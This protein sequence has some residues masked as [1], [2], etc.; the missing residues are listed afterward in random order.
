MAPQ[1]SVIMSAYNSS[2]TIERAIA[3]ILNQSFSDF[4]LIVM[5]DGSTDDTEEKILSIAD[6][7]IKYHPL[8]HSG[9]PRALNFGV[10]Q[11]VSEIMV[12]H[13]SDDWS[14]PDRLARQIRCL[15]K[16][17]DLALVASWHNVVDIDGKYLG[18][19]PTASDD[20]AIKKMLRWRNPFCHGSVAVRKSALEQ[21]GGYNEALLFTQDYDLWLKMA[22]SG[23]KFSCIPAPLY[24]YSITPDSIA[25]G[26]QK[27]GYAKK[28]RLNALQPD[29]H[30]NFSVTDL[31]A[32]GKRRTEAL[33]FYAIGSLALG[34]GDRRRALVYF[35]KSLLKNPLHWH[36][37]LKIG[38]A[39]LPAAA[40]NLVFDL[41]KKRS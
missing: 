31:S 24:N 25:K 35:L 26:W 14:E 28:I 11:A 39:L 40:A 13:D 37:Y 21:V 12:R 5:N 4:E 23:M 10:S 9:L 32:V 36:A 20:A 38:A 33:W 16:D 29:D 7:R 3:S 19:K 30:Q 8:D 41:V 22:A 18:L 27:L 15:E 2:E 1:L 34:D 6:E 17:K